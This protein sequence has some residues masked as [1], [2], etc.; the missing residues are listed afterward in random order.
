MG[1]SANQLWSPYRTLTI[2]PGTDSLFL[3]SLA[4]LPSSFQFINHS[5]SAT[6]GVYILKNQPVS[7]LLFPAPFADTTTMRYTVL[8]LPLNKSYSHKDTTIILPDFGLNTE[9]TYTTGITNEAFKPFEGLNSSGSISRGVSIGNNQDAVLNSSLNLQLSGDLGKGTAIR[10]SITDNSLPVQ[11]DGYTQQLQEFDK[12][13]IELE[14]ID[15]GL[16]R[17]GDYNMN[18]RK[19]TFLQFDKRISGAGVFSEIKMREGMVPLQLQG[20]IARG[21]FSRN[22]FQGEEG[23]QGPYKLQGNNSEQFIIIISGSERVYI[24]G[25]LMKRG[26]Q[27]DYVIDYN[28]GEITFTALRPIT[29]ERRIVVEFQYTEQNYLRTVAYGETGYSSKNFNTSIQF[30][31]EQDS[32]NQPL[33]QEFSDAEKAILASSGDNATL[34][35]ASTITPSE[36]RNDLVLYEL[37]DSLGFDSILVY[38]IDSTALLYQASFTFVGNNQGDYVLQQNNANG[39][40]FR[41]VPPVAGIKQGSYAPIK[42]L[43]APTQLQILALQTQGTIA[44]NHHLDVSLA[45]SKNDIN[46]LSEIDKQ[47]DQGYAGKLQYTFRKKIKKTQLNTGIYYEFNDNNF[48][49]IER[50]RNVEFSRDWNL[51]FNYNEGLQLGGLNIGLAGDSARARYQFEILGLNQYTGLKNTISGAL[52]NNRNVGMVAASWLTSTDSIATTNFIRQQAFFTRY[53]TARYWIGARSIGEW[54]KR[55]NTGTDSIRQGSYNFLEYQLYTGYGDTAKNF[56]EINYLERWDDTAR[57]GQYVNYSKATSYGIKTRYK[58][59][60][61]STLDI[62]VN[63]RNLKVMQPVERQLERTITSRFNYLQRFLANSITSTTFY[64]SGSGTE[65]RRFFSYLEVPAGTGTYTFTDYNGNGIK[66]LDEFEVAPTPDLAKYVRV[67]QQSNDYLRTNLLKLGQNL[68]INAPQAWRSKKDIR[69]SLYRFSV[70]LNYQLDRKTLLTGN[71]NNLNPFKE[72]EDDSVIVAL[73]NN[74]RSTLFFNRSSSYFGADYTYRQTDN[75]NLLSFGVEQRA[76]TENSMNLRI[77]PIEVL[78]LKINGAM[79]SKNNVSANFST[80]NFSI[81]Q[82][83]NKN[84]LSYQP[85]NKLVLTARYEIEQQASSGEQENNL[86]GQTV[87]LDVAYN[88]AEKISIL[89]SLNYIKND[90]SGSQNSPAGYE[91]LQALQPGNNSTWAL[92]IQRTLKKNILISLNYTGRT[93]ENIRPIHTGN[94][95]IKAFF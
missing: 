33:L 10:A 29:K 85:G 43:I 68:N 61:N 5:G 93:S 11:A 2:V 46:L 71:Q 92:T 19:N 42:Q 79:L 91:M 70:L 62:Q 6:Q 40:V 82:L 80:R 4:V 45:T 39:R 60:F 81:E 3:D 58:T 9:P 55:I 72:V 37:T 12:V 87:G 27:Y 86:S 7:Y 67:F 38:S 64:E 50:I 54:N 51:P 17:A 25:V 18:S 1:Q 95:E 35:R 44:E 57:F 83:Q 59:T 69:K 56:T 24:D 84:A 32:K 48:T 23:N 49:T 31:N 94:L 28:A 8:K 78:L 30:Y 63:V 22:R 47:N 13:Y 90:F 88:S 76:V 34:A 36:F 89:A 21:K 65:P 15:F 77:Q 66:E 14:N 75:R 73:N 20:G 53:L 74:F 26:E 16:L 52:K 41:W